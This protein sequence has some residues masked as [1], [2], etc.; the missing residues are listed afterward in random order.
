MFK[1]AVLGLLVVLAIFFHF[2]PLETKTVNIGCA[3]SSNYNFRYMK[4]ELADFRNFFKGQDSSLKPQC[5]TFGEKTA[6]FYL[7]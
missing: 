4:G 1:L 7:W 3:S 2:V 5:K 6:K